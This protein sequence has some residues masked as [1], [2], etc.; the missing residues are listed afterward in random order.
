MLSL[1]KAERELNKKLFCTAE[2]G[3]VDRV[4]NLIKNGVDTNAKDWNDKTPLHVATKNG[5]TEMVKFLL[6]HRVGVNERDWRQRIPLHGT[7][8]DDIC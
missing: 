4:R 2:E 5:H 6:E 3:N 1:R 8:E 7:T